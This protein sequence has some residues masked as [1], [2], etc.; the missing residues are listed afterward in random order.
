M[1]KLLRVALIICILGLFPTGCNFL[2]SPAKV[3]YEITG[4]ASTVYVTISNATGGTEQ[5]SGV[6][7][8]HTYAFEE[9]TYWYPYISAKNEGDSGSVTVTIYVDG[10]AVSTSTSDGAYVTATASYLRI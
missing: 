1:T 5:F 10:E 6:A 4:T 3:E 9:Y 7:V 8:P 2:A